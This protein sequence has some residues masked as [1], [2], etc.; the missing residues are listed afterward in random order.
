MT[1]TT[2]PTVTG[3]ETASQSEVDLKAPI[4]SPTFTGIVTTAGQVA[5]PAVQAPSADANTLDDYQEGVVTGTLSG[6]TTATYT[7]NTGTYTKVGRRVSFNL[8]MNI[9]LVGDGSTT[10]IVTDLPAA[11]AGAKAIGV[12]FFASSA[13][14][15]TSIGGFLSGSNITLYSTTAAQV[16]MAT[17]AIFQNGANVVISGTY[18]V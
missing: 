15:V 14:A 18:D 12:S 13:T 9:A 10:V 3:K 2:N 17:N 6:A 16:T 5:F 4:A 7:T 11:S 8:Q 1:V